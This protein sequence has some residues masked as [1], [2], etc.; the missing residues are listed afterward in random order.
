MNNYVISLTSATDRREHITQEFH[1]QGIDFDFFDAIT[2]NDLEKIGQFLGIDLNNNKILS[3]NELSCFCSHICLW[4]KAIDD[5]LDYITIF[6]DDIHLGENA[7]LFLNNYNWIPSNIDFVKLEKLYDKLPKSKKIPI[8]QQ[9]YLFQL[10]AEHTGGAGYILSNKMAKIAL[11]YAQ[12]GEIDH[13]DQILFNYFIENNIAPIYQLN[14]ALCMQD[15]RL[16]PNNQKFVS[17]L[18]WRDN[19]TPQEKPKLTPIQKIIREITRPFK[20]LYY[21]FVKPE[22]KLLFKPFKEK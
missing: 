17:S 2:P 14:P 12:N 8:T 20:Q 15:Y 19:I 22:I 21:F 11:S 9:H 1:R 16:Y 5:N 6:E 4:K 13:I 3:N 18:Q 7:H 10:K